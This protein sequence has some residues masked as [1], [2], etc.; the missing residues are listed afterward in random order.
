MIYQIETPRGILP[1]EFA[2]KQDA[3]DYAIG[4]LSWAGTKYRIITRRRSAAEEATAK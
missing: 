1:Y 3:M 4:I 2:T